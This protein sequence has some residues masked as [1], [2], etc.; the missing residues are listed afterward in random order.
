MPQY[1]C[2]HLD[3]KSQD[4]ITRDGY[5][6]PQVH[7]YVCITQYEQIFA[8]ARESACSLHVTYVCT[9]D[10]I[11]RDGYFCPQVHTYVC[12]TQ[13]EQIFAHARESACSLH[14]TYVCTLCGSV[15]SALAFQS[16]A[17]LVP[18]PNTRTH[19]GSGNK[20]ITDPE[21][22]MVIFV[23]RY[24]CCVIIS[25]HLHMQGRVLAHYVLHNYAVRTLRG[26]MVGAL[27]FDSPGRSLFF[28]Y[29]LLSLWPVCNVYNV[30]I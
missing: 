15:V 16:R 20:T 21:F 2:S 28:P 7:T 17:S 26:S 6:C 23:P 18:R 29:L 24:V 1:L 12:I 30:R 19:V 27:A 22:E 5:F 13:Y 4:K 9:L 10:K 25:K 8:H 14:V 11:T 3:Q